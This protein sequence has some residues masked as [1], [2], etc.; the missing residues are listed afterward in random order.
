MRK[1]KG[2]G[3]QLFLPMHLIMFLR[4]AVIGYTTV[5]LSAKGMAHLR[6]GLAEAGY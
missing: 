3:F 2:N 5:A 1:L 4:V 6:V